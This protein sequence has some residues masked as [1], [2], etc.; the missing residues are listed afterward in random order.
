M[1][2]LF[3]ISLLIL[4]VVFSGCQGI[5]KQPTTEP[6]DASEDSNVSVEADVAANS[7]IAGFYENYSEVRYNELLG[8]QPFAL[9]FHASWCPTCGIVEKDI[10]ENSGVFPEGTVILK[11]DYDKEK[12]LEAKYGVTSQ[13]LIVMIGADGA[14]KETLVSPSAAELAESFKKLL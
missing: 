3:A 7:T 6:S 5:D 14:A 2:I 10:L 9:F 4:A 11:A 12:A 1:K 13:S 8:K